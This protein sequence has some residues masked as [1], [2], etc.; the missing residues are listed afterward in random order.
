VLLKVFPGKVFTTED[1][2]ADEMKAA[3]DSHTQ[4]VAADEVAKAVKPLNDRI[5]ELAP[6]AADGKVYR[7]DLVGKYVANKAKLG[8]VDETPEA[9]DKV[10]AV[11]GAYPIDFLKSEVDVL[12]KRVDEKFPAGPQTRG[13][14]RTD[15]S[16]DISG[17]KDW[18]KNNPLTPKKEG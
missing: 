12:Q 9:Q 14:D 6:L 5:S 11:A 7:D 10:K 2:L 8:E 3:L 16:K 1:N 15:K 13:D 4:A 17:E 18:R